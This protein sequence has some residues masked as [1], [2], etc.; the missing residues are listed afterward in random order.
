MLAVAVNVVCKQGH[1]SDVREVFR[2]LTPPTMAEDGCIVFRAHVDRDDPR[3]ILI[4]ELWVDEAALQNHRETEHYRQ[5]LPVLDGLIE[6]R[7]RHLLN[8]IE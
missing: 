4:Y 7:D 5:Y 1:E 8:V 6:S 2:L 3:R